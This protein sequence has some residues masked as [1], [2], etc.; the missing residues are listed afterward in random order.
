LAYSPATIKHFWRLHKELRIR[1]DKLALPTRP[2]DF[3]EIVLRKNR[4]GDY[5]QAFEEQLTNF[6]FRLSLKKF[7]FAYMENTLNGEKSIKISHI[8]VNNRTK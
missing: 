7:H 8:S 4:M 6:V 1:G 2:D 5:T 3:K